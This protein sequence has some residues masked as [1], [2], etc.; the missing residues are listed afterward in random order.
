MCKNKENFSFWSLLNQVLAAVKSEFTTKAGRVNLVSDII[1]AAVVVA[2]FTVN[3]FEQ[4]AIIVVSIWNPAIMEYLSSADTLT[5]FI[6]LV[7]FS[8]LCL[9]FLFFYEK[10]LHNPKS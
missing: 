2:I 9:A 5:A 1:L 4:I 6:F 7:I 10:I 8:I 3:T